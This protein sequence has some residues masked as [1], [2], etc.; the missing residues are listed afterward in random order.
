[1]PENPLR[2]VKQAGQ[3]VWFDYI[4]RWE[5]VSGHLKHLIDEDGLSGV[6]SNPSIFEKAIAESKDYEEV[7]AKLAREGRAAA[8][9]F[10]TLAVEDIQMA[11]DLFEPTY[12]ATDAKD[13]YVSIEVSP[14]LARDTEGTIAEARQICRGG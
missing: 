2:E 11:A 5:M 6:T 9:I 1:M 14:T 12:R 4:R 8:E 13:G 3:S 10:E 7:I